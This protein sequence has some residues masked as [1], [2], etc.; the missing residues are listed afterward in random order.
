[1]TTTHRHTMSVLWALAVCL[2][3]SDQ[4]SASFCPLRCTCADANVNCANLQLQ[5]PPKAP[6]STLTLDLSN[7]TLGPSINDSDVFA[8]M[9][10]LVELDLSRNGLT[11][12]RGCIFRGLQG[13]KVVK[14][15]WNKLRALQD[16]IFTDASSVE[17]LDLSHNLLTAIPDNILA[18]LTRLQ[19]LK[20]AHNHLSDLRL[21]PRFQVPKDIMHIDLSYN[22][23]TA[24]R[25]NSF[26]IAS[27]WSPRVQRTINLSFCRITNVSAQSFQKIP[28]LR[29]L[30]LSG[31]MGV[32][33]AQLSAMLTN[34]RSSSL[35]QLSLAYMGLSSVGSLFTEAQELSL[36]TLNISHN[37]IGDLP[38]NVFANIPALRELDISHNNLPALTVGFTSLR[39]LRVLNISA[40]A[41]TSFQGGAVSSLG[42][43]QT[44][45]LSYNSLN[46]SGS[47]Q[48]SSLVKLRHLIAD[49]NRLSSVV[50]PSNTSTLTRLE[51]Q[52]NN[53]ERF[54]GVDDATSLEYVD[55]SDNKLESLTDSM[56]RGAKFLKVA[57]FSRN[58]LT[59]IHDHAFLPQSPLFIDLS[60]NSLTRI[61]PTK[62]VATQR[63]YLNNNKLVFIDGKAFKGM[64]GAESLD[65][66]SN[67]L[68]TVHED[69]LQ[70]HISLRSLNV[71]HNQIN[72]V[73]WLLLFRNLENLEVLD[74]AYNNISQLH[75]QMLLPLVKLRD[76]SLKHNHLKTIMPKIFRDLPKI[77]Q[78]DLS[79]NPLDCTCDMLAFRDWLKRMASVVVGLYGPNS[80]AYSCHGPARRA[81]AHATEWDT[82]DLE[83]NSAMIYVIIFGSIGVFLVI[84]GVAG[85]AGYRVYRRWKRERRAWKKKLA[86]KLEEEWRNKKIDY[87]RMTRQE[88]DDEI[89]EA[90]ARKDRRYDKYEALRR[91]KGYVPWGSGESYGYRPEVRSTQVKDNVMDGPR[92]GK[93]KDQSLTLPGDNWDPLGGRR[94]SDRRYRRLVERARHGYVDRRLK[95]HERQPGRTENDYVNVRPIH[96]DS[97]ESGVMAPS[98]QADYLM[99][100]ERRGLDRGHY[101]RGDNRYRAEAA[102]GPYAVHSNPSHRRDSTDTWGG[103]RYWMIPGYHR[104]QGYLTMPAR[105]RRDITRTAAQPSNQ[106]DPYP[107]G[108]HFEHDP[109][110]QRSD[111]QEYRPPNMPRSKSYSYLPQDYA[112]ERPFA[113]NSLVP[114]SGE[115]YGASIG[116]AISQPFLATGNTSDWL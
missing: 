43:L 84:S 26:D 53:I 48:L 79:Y 20:L 81:G 90:L 69:L 106:N 97:F 83:C 18:Y 80:T 70:Y 19:T 92:H 9:P 39:N 98:V 40:N 108:V 57:D 47:V 62:W 2:I 67:Q 93:F 44:L 3:L 113:K 31:N 110:R 12:L 27:E 101:Y 60:H 22:N 33:L 36:K 59:A 76:I 13:L 41:L 51:Y 71:S 58:K 6:T 89:Q 65:L 50:L 30:D 104:G 45:V 64:S 55:L 115:R 37:S 105:S 86:E 1:M 46:S 38:A 99:E 91:L 96:R 74:L 11:E 54:H 34:L 14:L 4:S 28:N 116:R 102:R 95:D 32:T 66:S 24:V 88:I 21:M 63:L 16:N 23:F 111:D 68:D 109:R 17:H 15:G 61:G 103:S 10:G 73:S 7:N 107:P 29:S 87:I 114:D 42:N 8:A 56:F 112:D 49:H 75:E 72:N 78:I 52:S 82:G 100:R 94:D 35:A 5:A 25:D 77:R 85:S